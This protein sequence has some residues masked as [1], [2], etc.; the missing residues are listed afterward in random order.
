ML[1]QLDL[2]ATLQSRLQHALQQPIVTAQNVNTSAKVSFATS[3]PSSPRNA[4]AKGVQAAW[5][6]A[7]KT[8]IP[9][10]TLAAA[11]YWP[12][13][14]GL[15]CDE[16]GFV[17]VH[18]TLQSRSHP[19]VFA[20]GDCAALDAPKSGVYALR[21]GET[22]ARSFANLVRGE[23]PAD[24]VPQA[25]ALLLLSCGGKRAI[26]HW[27]PWAAQGAWAWQ[28]KNWIDRRWLRELG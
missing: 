3:S 13:S 27:G 28:W 11:A 17:A 7:R 2:Q 15:E 4:C 26:A 23:P 18:R 9:A 12:R 6:A 24:F 21:A 19:E 1:G 8:V 25:R 10:A 16:R 22:L 5:K 20:A 14:S